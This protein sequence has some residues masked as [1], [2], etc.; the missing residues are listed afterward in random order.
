MERQTDKCVMKINKST[1]CNN[2]QC[3]VER[4]LFMLQVRQ[5]DEDKLESRIQRLRD[6]L[7]VHDPQ[8]AQLVK[9]DSAAGVTDMQHDTDRQLMSVTDCGVQRLKL[10]VSLEYSACFSTCCWNSVSNFADWK[11]LTMNDLLNH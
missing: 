11:F 1:E 7:F 8:L 9:H 10:S 6:N 5:F 4:R 3:S 2:E